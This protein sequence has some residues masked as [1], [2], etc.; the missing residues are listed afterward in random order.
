MHIY[1]M[2]LIQ[3]FISVY[4]KS[5]KFLLDDVYLIESLDLSSCNVLCH[6]RK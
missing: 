3:K 1:V 2:I 6:M 4:F 5:C